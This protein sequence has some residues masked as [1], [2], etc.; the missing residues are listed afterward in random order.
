MHERLRDLVHVQH[1]HANFSGWMNCEDFRN[2][3]FHTPRTAQTMVVNFDES[4]HNITGNKNTEIFVDK[5]YYMSIVYTY[6]QTLQDTSLYVVCTW[7]L[8]NDKICTFAHN[9]RQTDDNI[10]SFLVL[11]F[12]VQSYAIENIKDVL[13]CWWI[14]IILSVLCSKVKSISYHRKAYNNVSFF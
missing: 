5:S 9:H 3:C 1:M 6:M 10:K 7:R 4:V 14:S 13:W 12:C 8:F 2:V 11:L